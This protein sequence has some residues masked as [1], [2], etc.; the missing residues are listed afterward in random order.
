[1]PRLENLPQTRISF[2]RSAN[3]LHIATGEDL[4]L[5][6]ARAILNLM[7]CHSNDCN[8]FFID[9]R[10]VTRIQPAAAAALRGAPQPSIAPQRIHYKGSRGFELAT[11]GNK[12]LIVPEKACLQGH[13]PQLPLQG[14]KGPRQG[15]EYGPGG[16]G[17]GGRRCCLMDVNLKQ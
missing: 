11:S 2:R 12:V 16:R 5:E 9:V 13:L 7:R 8:K 6:Q 3:N 1:M 10:H 4:D 17:V 15:A 14:Q